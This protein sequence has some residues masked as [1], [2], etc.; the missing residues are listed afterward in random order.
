VLEKRLQ[1]VVT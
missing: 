1:A